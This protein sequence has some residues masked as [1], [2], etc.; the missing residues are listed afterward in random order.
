MVI[1]PVQTI[2]IITRCHPNRMQPYWPATQCRPFDSPAAGSVTDAE[3]DDDRRQR[4]LGW[5]VTIIRE[6]CSRIDM[7]THAGQV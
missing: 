3:D 4:A 1:I 5:P 7:Q 6:M 2:V